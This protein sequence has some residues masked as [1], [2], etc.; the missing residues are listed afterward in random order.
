MENV[1]QELTDYIHRIEEEKGDIALAS[2]S[3]V[4][5][6]KLERD[7]NIQNFDLK[8]SLSLEAYHRAKPQEDCNC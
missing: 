8:R 5:R 4:L 1:I 6:A 3:P 7:Y 2:W